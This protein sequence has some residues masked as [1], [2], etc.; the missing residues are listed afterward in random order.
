MTLNAFYKPGNVSSRKERSLI[1]Q[2]LGGD[3]IQRLATTLQVWK[4]N[5][6]PVGSDRYYQSGENGCNYQ[7]SK[8]CSGLAWISTANTG[9]RGPRRREQTLCP[10]QHPHTF[11]T[12]PCLK[13]PLVGASVRMQ[14]SAWALPSLSPPLDGK[15]L[16]ESSLILQPQI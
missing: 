1:D 5:L 4:Q 14:G 15:L 2:R 9:S 3:W 6:T 8:G 16:M 10:R 11:L 7:A 12:G 13:A